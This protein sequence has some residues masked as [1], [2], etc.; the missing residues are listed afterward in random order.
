VLLDF[1]FYTVF[2]Q[3]NSNPHLHRTLLNNIINSISL[4]CSSNDCIQSGAGASFCPAYN[5]HTAIITKLL[6][7]IIPNF[8]IEIAAISTVA[9]PALSRIITTNLPSFKSCSPVSAYFTA[10]EHLFELRHLKTL[11]TAIPVTNFEVAP[12]TPVTAIK[13]APDDVD[14]KAASTEPVV[15][16]AAPKATVTV[17]TTSTVT[18][19]N[20]T[21]TQ[22]ASTVLSVDKTIK[23]TSIS[24]KK[25][26]DLK[27]WLGDKDAAAVLDHFNPDGKLTPRKVY[28]LPPMLDGRDRAKAHEALD[29]I[30]GNRLIHETNSRDQRMHLWVP[31]SVVC[32]Y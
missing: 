32:S 23:Y 13:V 28:T 8:E 31:G 15:E 11:K 14:T 9:K 12:K 27:W 1:F 25:V 10:R 7:T 24:F 22:G 18:K 17:P 30:Y 4:P 29:K 6:T 19:S 21:A 3:S 5:L 2:A 26:E 16:K 20:I